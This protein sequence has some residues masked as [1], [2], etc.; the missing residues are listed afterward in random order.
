MPTQNAGLNSLLNQI[1][2][3]YKD[4]A[5]STGLTK[6]SPAVHRALQ[7]VPRELFVDETHRR[8]AY[9]NFPLPIG[10]GQTISQPFIVALMT[11]LLQLNSDSRVLEIGTGCGYQSAILAEIAKEVYT[12]EIV[13]ELGEAANQRLAELGYQ[14]IHYR[15]GDGAVGWPEAAPFDGIIAT[16]CGTSI[17]S[18]WI[19][20]MAGPPLRRSGRIVMPLERKSG[21]QEL[22][23][24]SKNADGSL[25]EQSVLAVRFV[26]ITH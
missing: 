12:V 8:D 3:D 20:Q 17:P 15:T 10:S 19:E 5:A 1:D 14:N 11:D 2:I 13:A 26:P 4:T 6:M 24:I 7:S 23:V 18:A 9:G 22:V 16:A 21:N 25:D